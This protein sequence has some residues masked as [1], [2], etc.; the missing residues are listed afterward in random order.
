M[1]PEQTTTSSR[2]PA[3]VRS[4]PTGPTPNVRASSFKRA[5]QNLRC[6]DIART[7]ENSTLGAKA[8]T[9]ARYGIT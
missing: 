9:F 6:A 3:T 8:S 7:G 5:R 1:S 4:W 2:H